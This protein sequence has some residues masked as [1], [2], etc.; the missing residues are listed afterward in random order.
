MNRW[1]WYAGWLFAWFVAFAFLFVPLSN[2]FKEGGAV[3]GVIRGLILTSAVIVLFLGV[4]FIHRKFREAATDD[5]G[6]RARSIVGAAEG[7]SDREAA[8][9]AS[10]R[11][12]AFGRTAAL[13]GDASVRRSSGVADN[14]TAKAGSP[15]AIPAAAH[16]REPPAGVM[17]S[18]GNPA[19]RRAFAQAMKEVDTRTCEP[20][21]WAMALVEC[22]GDEKAARIA[23]MRQRAAEIVWSDAR[24]AAS[25]QDGAHRNDT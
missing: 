18:A 25:A 7:M 24:A 3:F 15:S 5:A 9:V 22:N 10:A 2:L 20:G 4:R 16:D 21:L 8:L 12:E 23:Y 13:A 14:P 11:E 19:A 1:L 6:V 17:K